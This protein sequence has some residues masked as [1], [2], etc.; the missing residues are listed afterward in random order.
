MRTILSALVLSF[1]A[2]PAGA[3]TSALTQP[4]VVPFTL[5]EGLVF[6]EATL[7]DSTSLNVILDTGGG[8]DVF[9]PRLVQRVGGKAMG[10]VTGHRMTGE[11]LDIDLWVVPSLRVGPLTRTDAVV[12]T[13]AA[14]DN[15][16][17][18]GIV[19][20]DG[21]RE[22]PFTIDFGAKTVTFESAGSLARRR[23]SGKVSQ[24]QLDDLRGRAV[25]AFADF[26]LGSEL[27]QCEL[28]TGSQAMRANTRYLAAFGID[29]ADASVT[30]RSFKTVTG[31]TESQY[32]AT[33]P[34]VSLASAADVAASD[35][36]VTF[37]DI[38]Y[39]CVIGTEFWKGR[40]VTFDVAGRELIVAR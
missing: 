27:G 3:Q 35:V 13:W 30:R 28:D 36:S 2:L 32:V 7:G 11:R 8:L 18:D 14:L 10:V 22:Q 21:F 23:A 6:I 5:N 39:D 37:S 31:A 4:V 26:E 19:S 9:S 33:V 25:T 40:T 15:F 34:L 24:L 1:A 12:G 38:I 17:L 20:L 16:G 29:T